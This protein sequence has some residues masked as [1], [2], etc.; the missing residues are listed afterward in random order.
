MIL[1]HVLK[2]LLAVSI[3]FSGLLLQLKAQF[4]SVGLP[5]IQNFT[6]SD[7]N[8]G[9]QNWGIAQYRNGLI[10]FGNN[11]GIVEYD[12]TYWHNYLYPNRTIGRSLAFD[13]KGRLYVGGQDELGY[14]EPNEKGIMT[15]VS[16]TQQIPQE[17]RSFAD[18]WEIFPLRD[19]TI[20][21]THKFIFIYNEDG[22]VDVITPSTL[23]DVFFQVNGQIYIQDADR[24]LMKLEGKKLLPIGDDNYFKDIGIAVIL[25]FDKDE[26]LIISHANGLFLMKNDGKIRSW[27]TP[28]SSF[29]KTY[30]AYC[31]TKL[32]DG[33]YAI[34]T[35]HNG[36][37]IMDRNGKPTMHLNKDNG[38]QNNTI[39]SVEQDAA[40]NLWLG[41]DNGIAYLEIRS[42][43]SIIQSEVG[44]EGTGYT[45]ILHEGKLFLGTNQG[46]YI[47]DWKN[48]QSPLDFNKFETI[49]NSTGQVWSLQVL[50]GELLMGHHEGAFII[51][52]GRAE[53]IA[54]IQGIWKFI[55]LNDHPNYAI[56]GAYNGLYLFAKQGNTWAF[57]R[58]LNGF[59]ES[60][61][62][63]EEDANGYI[64]IAHAYKGLYKIT[65]DQD[66][67]SVA[68]V[69]FYNSEHNLPTDLF[70]NV[71]KV[72]GELVFTTPQGI[73]SYNQE[74]DSFEPHENLSQIFAE[75]KDIHRLIED[76]NG[77]IWFS[78]DDEF[79]VLK[80]T[81]KGVLNKLDKFYF[82]HIHDEL[83][84]GFENIYAADAQNIF[85]AVEKGFIQ[86]DVSAQPTAPE[87]LEVF[88]RKVVSING[89]DSLI[90]GG[91]VMPWDSTKSNIFPY[92]MN[93]FRFTYSA[94][95]FEE[96]GYIQYRY[97]LEGFDES[98]SAWSSQTEKEY[99]NLPH[100]SYTFWVEARN[101]EA[102]TSDPV[103]YVFAIRPPWYL[104]NVAKGIYALSGILLLLGVARFVSKRIQNQKEVLR[105]EQARTLKEKEAEYKRSKEKSEA[106][107]I[108]LRNEKLKADINH[109]TS[110][111]ASATMHLV[112]KG[113]ILSDLKNN[114][115]KLLP[116][117]DQENQRKVNQLI[118]AIDEDS[119]LD[120]DWDQFEIHFDQ[121]HENFLKRLREEYP[122]LT[123][124][125]QKLCAYLRM[126][127][128]TKEIAP[129]MNISVRGVEISRYRLRKK[130]DID[131]DTN[132]VEFIMNI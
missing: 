18:V 130:L 27:N 61:R 52:N 1:S 22:T 83:V 11:K 50:D 5:A 67:Q 112:Q 57:V 117:I 73:F 110:E 95:H 77:D 42:P 97:Q 16:L 31:G 96:A 3:L 128:T 89:A 107:I 104:T 2:K 106:E 32:T 64:W 26:S 4:N 122:I 38:L 21:C 125:D 115:K 56:A 28:A 45:S 81:E 24:G 99:T 120:G 66:F 59:D 105:A 9:T 8:A 29:L 43:F 48:R 132:L 39:L 124:K 84:D 44:L 109:K 13:E 90:W 41:L 14:L 76:E 12:G 121:V 126:N 35:P 80:V 20:F 46:L 72:R 25:P 108:R 62:I 54:D 91:S 111:L 34:G 129:L 102:K 88:I 100:G 71:S 82:N 75:Y 37:L 127:L 49:P 94:P 17:Y 114:L 30:R 93:A 92:A 69:A 101:S 55:Q 7:Y 60:A 58:K 87:E 6:K 85:I 103:R 79:G 98:W 116:N 36:L 74:S 19:R 40:G 15:Y 65:L 47:T 78:A 131:S 51:K 119:R 68:D 53:K 118:K 86:L 23:F 123:P 10:Y 63:L 33:R 113:E 70:I